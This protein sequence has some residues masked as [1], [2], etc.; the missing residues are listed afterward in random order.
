MGW[1]RYYGGLFVVCLWDGGIV[2]VCVAIRAERQS[3]TL[4]VRG[5]L[6]LKGEVV[7]PDTGMEAQRPRLRRLSRTDYIAR[8]W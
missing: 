7:L 1:V 2:G 5:W 4:V 6:K 8:S 3:W